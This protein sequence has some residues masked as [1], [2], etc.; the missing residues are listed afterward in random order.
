MNRIDLNG[1][2]TGLRLANGETFRAL[3]P[4]CVHTD[5]QR[6]GWLPEDL[7]WRDNA[8]CPRWIEKEEWQYTKKFYI[9]Q[10]EPGATLV[11]ECLD[12]YSEIYLN[13]QKIGA[14]ENMFI[15]HR[16][17]VDE[18]ILEGENELTVIFHSPITATKDCPIPIH[19][20]TSERLFTRRMQCTYGWDWVMRFVTCGIEGD[21]YMEFDNGP[22]VKDSY[23]YTDAIDEFGAQVVVDVEFKNYSEGFTYE[24]V[25]CDPQ[26]QKVYSSHRFCEEP[27]R[28]EYICISYPQLWN[29]L[30]YGKQSLYTLRIRIGVE[31][32]EQ[33]FGIRTVRILEQPDEPGTTSYNL[34]LALRDTKSGKEY[35]F[36]EQFS[37]FVLVVNHRRVLCKGA[38]WAPC[39]PFVSEVTNEKQTRILELA[40]AAG[41]NMIRV[42]GG[43]MFEKEHFYRECDRLGIM[44]TQDFLMACGHYP[45]EEEWFQVAIKQE[46]EF[47]ARH[48]RNHPC[49]MWWTGDNENA[50]RGNDQMKTYPGRTSA[51]KIMAPVLKRLDPMRRFLPSSPY[52]GD[53]YA[54]KTRG[55]TH[56]TQFLG[57]LFEYIEHGDMSNYRE[58]YEEY[59]A[60]FIA[61]EPSMGAISS[62]SLRRFMTEH[63]IMQGEE[64]WR[65]HTQSNPELL[66]ELFD[67]ELL[68][69]KGLFGE[70]HDG[71]DRLF[72][73]QYLQYEW[74]RT[75]FEM[76]RRNM[77]FSSGILYWMLADCWPAASGWALIDYYCMPK[78]SYYSFKRCA[79]DLVAS[80]TKVA[81]ECI[82][83]LCNST[84]DDYLGQ[85]SIKVFDY[86]MQG[87]NSH[88]AYEQVLENVHIKGEMVTSL[89]IPF[90]PNK[91]QILI[92][93]MVA[94]NHKDR[95]F[96]KHGNLELMAC[97]GV[98]IV[99]RTEDSITLKADCY[100]HAVGLEGNYIFEDNYFSLL[101]QEERTVSLSP[102]PE[103][104]NSDILI[105]AYSLV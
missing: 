85:L 97:N 100:V 9:E 27:E 24:L 103:L 65:Y 74:I 45:E 21:C 78:A 36:N 66:K 38:N 37:S 50:I 18:Q 73:L 29:P 98:K 105:K 44:V 59:M 20:F 14:T 2:W 32:Y 13:G 93:D 72:K 7:Y 104:K 83:H 76:M 67:Y 57:T 80:I 43:G 10:L 96:Y 23:I 95:A 69:A 82:L 86:G 4:G 87:N 51:V 90:V 101:P 94:D 5:L 49:L 68:F 46:T 56:N 79:K 35:D 34:C 92:C 16:F 91:Q 81:E 70:F 15:P 31:V 71:E 26:G 55:T 33:Q 12:T 52:G 99:N 62:V 28:R 41:I 60:R 58:D 8:E 42:W 22:R 89:S 63:D 6:A 39:E 19:S 1:A 75:S 40:A 64:M 11:F 54:S 77:W 84:R 47:A 3:V 88:I 102:V 48:L 53:Y 17:S 30:G 61:E 25:V